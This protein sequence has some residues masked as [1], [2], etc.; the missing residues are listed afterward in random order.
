LQA[1]TIPVCVGPGAVTLV[2]DVE[3]DCTVLEEEGDVE[4]VDDTEVIVKDEELTA[5]LLPSTQ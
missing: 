2:A 5:T 4:V 1:E 3:V